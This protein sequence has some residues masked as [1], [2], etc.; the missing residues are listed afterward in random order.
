M[1]VN[2]QQNQNEAADGQSRA[3]EAGANL[4][5][6]LAAV[7]PKPEYNSVVAGQLLCIR[8]ALVIDDY[9]EAYHLLYL[10]ADPNLSSTEPWA[11]MERKAANVE[12]RGCAFAESGLNVG[13]APAFATA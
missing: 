2:Q 9:A 13:L 10:I 6:G 5:V 1:N 8:D 7:D 11:E 4:S 3:G 12:L